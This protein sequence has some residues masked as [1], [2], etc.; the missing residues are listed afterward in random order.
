MCRRIIV[1]TYDEV[2][3]VIRHL[4]VGAPLSIDADWPARRAEAFP[5]SQVTAIV[6]AGVA[7]PGSAPGGAGAGDSRARGFPFAVSSLVPAEL[8]WGFDVPWSG[9]LVYNTRIE[10]AARPGG[11]WERAIADGRCIVPT[12][13]FFEPHRGETVPSPRTGKPVKRPY[14]FG[15][16]PAGG[17]AE[18]NGAPRSSGSL[19]GGSSAVRQSNG[20]PHRT[21]RFRREAPGSALR[22]PDGR[23]G[24]A[25]CFRDAAPGSASRHPETQSV[26]SAFAPTLTLLGGV[27]QD[28][29]LSIVTTAPNADVASVHDRMPLV[30][31]P[32][33]VAT[34]LSPEYLGLADRSAVS[35]A[36]APADPAASRGRASGGAKANAGGDGFG[37]LSLF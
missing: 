10:T 33:E 18:G 29:R 27:S 25:S 24:C 2:L 9:K 21:D 17:D 5:G 28:G 26:P 35:L 12:L 31:E 34:W 23:S 22:Q 19:V 20:S 30:I 6:P 8:T 36:S 14:V 4:E 7:S 1:L 13:G 3:D 11:M 32:W 37:Q 15:A 16:R